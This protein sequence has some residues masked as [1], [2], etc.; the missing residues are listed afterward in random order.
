P[1]FQRSFIDERSV[2]PVT[3]K[4][5]HLSHWH[6]AKEVCAQTSS[7]ER[8][9]LPAR[10]SP[11][12]P[13]P[14]GIDSNRPQV[15]MS[16]EFIG[17]RHRHI[18]APYCTDSQTQNRQR[19][20]PTTVVRDP[21]SLVP[22]AATVSPEQADLADLPVFNHDS[23]GATP[24]VGLKTFINHRSPDQHR[25]KQNIAEQTQRSETKAQDLAS[26]QHLKQQ[27][28]AG[29]FNPNLEDPLPSQMKKQLVLKIISGQQLP[30]PKDSM[31][32][33][34]GEIIDPFVE[35]EIIGLPVDCCKEQTRVVDDNGFNPMWVETLVFTVHMP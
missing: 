12:A 14:Q 19:T 28:G 1:K 5:Q 33:D 25:V 16:R 6:H 34:R 4:P 7:R 18:T 27:A 2:F 20:A 10:F 17:E 32:G 35:V 3:A 13:K 9:P 15:N 21:S 23:S 11:G 30:K 29:A 24:R 26:A 8:T 31:L 22:V